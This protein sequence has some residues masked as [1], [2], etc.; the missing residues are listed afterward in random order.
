ML[1]KIKEIFGYNNNQKVITI[2]EK[3]PVL[4][5]ELVFDVRQ[6]VHIIVEKVKENPQRL[7]LI[8]TC[9]YY[10][11][12]NPNTEYYT[13]RDKTTLAKFDIAVTPKVYGIEGEYTAESITIHND[14]ITFTTDE[15]NYLTQELK[16]I[17]V[18]NLKCRAL[19]LGKLRNLRKE[20]KAQRNR[21]KMQLAWEES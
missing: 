4:E 1:N 21:T 17:V 15:M 3:S 20:R 2:V 7:K 16:L 6:P 9:G 19:R 18:S 8:A 11:T 12:L 10:F 5:E 14:D 13:L